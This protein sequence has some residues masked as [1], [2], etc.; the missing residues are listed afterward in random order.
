[1]RAAVTGCTSGKRLRLV[2]GTAISAPGGG[3]AEWRLHMGYDPHTC[4]FTD[5]ELTDSRDA[6]RLDRFA[7]TADEI[8]IADRGFGSRPECIRSLAFGEADYIV[9]VHWRGLRW[10]TAEGMRF[11]MMGFLR[12]LDCGKNGE[13]TVMI[14][15]SGNKKA[16]APFPARLIAVSLPPEKALISKTRLLSEN[17]RKGRV[18]QAETLEA[19]GHVLLL[20]SLPED[21]YSAEQVADCY[22]LRWQIELAF[23]RLKSLLHLDALRAKEPE[24]AK[25]WIFAN[26][27]AAFL[28]D[29]IIQPSL[30]FPPRSAGSEKKN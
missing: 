18:V 6:E 11:D 24:L 14:G 1:V 26:L 16:G 30:D 13:T 5:F 21:E 3:S 22:R 7:Q 29:D 25:A 23:K 28:I 20:T 4:Q 15:N 9:R 17:R 12:G 10:L 2:D 19:A 27:L 8:R